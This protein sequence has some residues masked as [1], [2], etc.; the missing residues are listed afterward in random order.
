[1]AKTRGPLTLLLTSR[2][3]RWWAI[4]F[5]VVLPLLYVLSSGPMLTL[6]W[7]SHLTIIPT[8][9][10]GPVEALAT[11]DQGAWWPTVYAPLWW[12]SEKSWGA[13]PLQWYWGLFPIPD[14]SAADS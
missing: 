9:P 1:M 5:A 13:A 8:T 11:L 4:G 2:R 3:F 12:V 14:E 10:D 6:A 7:R